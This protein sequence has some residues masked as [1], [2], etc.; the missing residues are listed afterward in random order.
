MAEKRVSVILPMYNA[1]KTIK[2]VL[3]SIRKQT[4]FSE[5]LEIL[6]IDDGSSDKSSTIVDEYCKC[7]S[8]MPIRYHFQNN[9][10]VSVARNVGLK[11]AKG[12]FIAFLDSDDIWLENKLERQLEIFDKNSEIVFLGAAH[13][14]KTFK[15]FGKT[16]TS[17]YNAKLED[18]LW[19]YFPVTPSVIFRKKAINKV[20]YFDENQEYCEDINYYLKFLLNYNYYYLPEKLVEIDCDKKYIR[21][22]GLSSNLRMMH[23]GEMKNLK[24][25]YEQCYLPFWKYACFWLFT[26]MKYFRRIIM[27]LFNRIMFNLGYLQTPNSNQH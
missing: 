24:E 17:L 12:E 13:T 22:K 26:E 10:G 18:V 19:S 23:K 25:V 1:E 2:N 6:I 9:S 14:E 7:Y 16:I 8:F 3:D 21:E 11:T 5:I 4:R 15:R 20:G 27:T